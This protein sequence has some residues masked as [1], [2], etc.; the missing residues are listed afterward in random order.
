M[1]ESLDEKRARQA[2]A[3]EACAQAQRSAPDPAPVADFDS[4]RR[5]RETT[6]AT[7]RAK[8][9]RARMAETQAVHAPL[10]RDQ[11][12]ATREH[13][14]NT[15]TRAEAHRNTLR[16]TNCQLCDTDGYRGATICDHIDHSPAARRGMA[17]IR[18]ALSKENHP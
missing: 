8:Q 9:Q 1:P 14:Q 5:A 11:A 4:R 2:A 12:Q 15:V 17:L 13:R 10:S 16:I 6:A 3:R 18:Q 7:E